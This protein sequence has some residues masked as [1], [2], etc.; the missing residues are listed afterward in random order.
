MDDLRVVARF[1]AGSAGEV[2][3]LF[4]AD[5]PGDPR[6]RVAVDAAR[7]FAVGADRTTLQRVAAVDAHRAAK[8]AVAEAAKHA[9]HAA[10]DAAAA[11]YLHP[12][13]RASQ[14]GHILRATAHAA[15]AAELAA[16][17][18]PA[19]GDRCVE[20][21]GRRATPGL[22]DVLRRYPAAPTGKNRV[23]QLMTALDLSLRAGP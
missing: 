16:G 10:G 7:S 22:V 3:Q 13:A 1:A 5:R 17:G 21:A 12:L 14:V 20:R 2:L 4:E 6:P 18:A 11:A 23:A 9:A 8:D 15:R 19:V